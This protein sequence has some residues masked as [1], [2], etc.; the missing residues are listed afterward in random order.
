MNYENVTN[1][2]KEKKTII[3]FTRKKYLCIIYFAG[4][5]TPPDVLTTLVFKING[6]VGF[7]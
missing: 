2:L 5:L 3:H 7:V 6:W 4:T 1:F